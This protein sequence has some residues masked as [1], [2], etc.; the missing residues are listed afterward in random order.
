MRKIAVK[1]ES[2]AQGSIKVREVKNVKADRR[3]MIGKYVTRL[4]V[5]QGAQKLINLEVKS[6]PDISTVPQVVDAIKQ[7]ES[8]L[9]ENGRVLVR[10]SG[11]QNMCRVMVEGP[12][13]DVTEKYCQQIADVV[14]TA[15]N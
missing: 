13:D 9:G 7:V 6:K 2:S 1:K 15:L 12:S 14:R 5:V 11:T 4:S 8:D 10:Y 3:R